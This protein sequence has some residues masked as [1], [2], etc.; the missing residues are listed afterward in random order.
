MARLAN[1]RLLSNVGWTFVGN[2][3]YAASQW[4]MIVVLARCTD[5]ATVG[6]FALALAITAPVT[7]LFNMQ[8]RAVIAT[9]VTGK[10]KLQQ[11]FQARLFTA[12]MA[13]LIICLGLP[14][15]RQDRATSLV[16][17][18]VALSKAGESLSDI[19][20]GHWQLIERME[21]VGRSLAI[22]AVLTLTVFAVAI[23]TTHS[24]ISAAGAFLLGSF[25]VF[26]GNDLPTAMSLL[27][28]SQGREGP[29]CRSS[30]SRTTWGTIHSLVTLAAP[31]GLAAMLIS[32]NTSIPR[33]FIEAYDGKHQ[34]GI[35][36]ALSYFIVVGNLCMNAVGQTVLPRLAT[37][38][39]LHSLAQFWRGFKSLLA[40][41][42]IVALASM[43]VVLLFG[44]RLLE[45]YGKEYST[46]YPVFVAIMGAASIGYFIAILNFALN[47]V[48]AY[49]IQAPLLLAVSATLI[50]LC[51]ILIPKH[52]MLGAGIALILSNFIQAAISW[53]I[54]VR[55]ARTAEGAFRWVPK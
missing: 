24:L 52:G 30:D 28:N 41:S 34:L 22:R 15:Y 35:F 46:A 13:L 20:H 55:R 47:A 26:I 19:I 3:L 38:Y 9:D 51:R 48:G 6:S 12:A 18:L 27:R 4:V 23:A 11:Y 37:L 45:I 32:L 50:M 29:W 33:Y 14:F 21:L 53:V 10:Y 2:A 31:L 25:S 49:K 1:S 36:A 39:T 17:I 44:R 54:L 42:G 7:I 43:V 8:L 16:I 5:P 40:C